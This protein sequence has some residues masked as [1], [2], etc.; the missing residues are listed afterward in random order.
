MLYNLTKTGSK[1]FGNQNKCEAAQ[2]TN[3]WHEYLRCKQKMTNEVARKISGMGKLKDADDLFPPSSSSQRL[4]T[5]ISF[6]E[7][8]GFQHGMKMSSTNCRCVE[9]NRQWIPDNWCG[10]CEDQELKWC[11]TVSWRRHAVQSDPPIYFSQLCTDDSEI[12]QACISKSQLLPLTVWKVKVAIL[13]KIRC[14]IVSN[15]MSLF[16]HIHS[17]NHNLLARKA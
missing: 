1:T 5:R 9:V 11:F 12:S 15:K 10:K 13:N 8:M 4:R 17:M 6:F 2:D 16:V 3:G 14:S 7:Q